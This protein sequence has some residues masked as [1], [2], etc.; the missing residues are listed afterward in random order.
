ME[1]KEKYLTQG[2]RDVLKALKDYLETDYQPSF[3]DMA[4]KA[5]VS[6]DTVKKAIPRLEELQMIEVF[7]PGPRR[8][9][10]YTIMDDPPED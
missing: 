2:Q 6:E 4:R 3:Q 7:R 9:N 5:D 1:N 8:K 10:Y